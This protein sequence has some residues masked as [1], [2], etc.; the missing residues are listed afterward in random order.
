MVTGESSGTTYVVRC[1][2]GV[3]LTDTDE[4]TLI[5]KMQSHTRTRHRVEFTD[6]QVKLLVETE[7]RQRRSIG[8]A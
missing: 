7:I 5:R 8:A 3:V 2:C 4:E 1:E 6:E